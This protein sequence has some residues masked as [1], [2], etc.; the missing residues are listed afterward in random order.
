MTMHFAA[1]LVVRADIQIARQTSQLHSVARATSESTDALS[2]AVATL[3]SHW[4]FECKSAPPPP[5]TKIRARTTQP[6]RLPSQDMVQQPARSP[7][8]AFL[9]STPWVM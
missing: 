5:Q 3:I 2:F 8:L 7:K 6:A 1:S 4:L 9:R